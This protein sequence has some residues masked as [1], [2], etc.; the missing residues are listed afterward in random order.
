MFHTATFTM[1]RSKYKKHTKHRNTTNNSDL[2]T[3]ERL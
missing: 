3:D 1:T 2:C